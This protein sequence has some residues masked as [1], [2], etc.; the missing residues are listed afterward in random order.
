MRRPSPS[1]EPVTAAPIAP[2]EE[3]AFHRLYR[4]HPG[5]GHWYSESREA[6]VLAAAHPERSEHVYLLA[7]E[8]GRARGAL[9]L[10]SE[11]GR[12]LT[13][14]FPILEDSGEPAPVL[15]ALGEGAV[16]AARRRGA[17][18]IESE[19]AD[20]PATREL[21]ARLPA[22]GLS[23]TAERLILRLDPQGLPDARPLEPLDDGAARALTAAIYP[24]SEDPAIRT[25][26]ADDDLA[27][28]AAGDA[29]A[30]PLGLAA[31]AGPVGVTWLRMGPDGGEIVFTGV[32]PS[33]RR[34]GLGRELLLRSIAEIRRRGGRA[35]T[36]AV[37]VA[38][39]PARELYLDLGFRETSRARLYRREV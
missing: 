13:C 33:R 27:L 24:T 16:A 25:V 21:E 32:H 3:R 4:R 17:V 29:A 34:E 35:A 19:V 2:G 38:N 26:P 31:G 30:L 23:P 12:R 11:P 28:F 15:A 22:L 20:D 10:T 37:S 9:A 5:V 18:R 7:R 14:H 39:V 1:A 36:L 6:L 8:D